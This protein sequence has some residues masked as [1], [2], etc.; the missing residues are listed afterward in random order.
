MSTIY[1]CTKFNKPISNSSLIFFHLIEAKYRFHAPAI[2]FYIL[3]NISLTKAI[4]LSMNYYYILF[5]RL[6]LSGCSMAHTSQVC[7]SAML[8]QGVEIQK[9]GFLWHNVHNKL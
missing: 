8:L 6:I 2:L 4:Y 3:Q 1:L 9:Y 7:I 5:L